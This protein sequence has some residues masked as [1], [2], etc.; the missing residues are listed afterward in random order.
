MGRSRHFR[1]GLSLP[2]HRWR[3]SVVPLGPTAAGHAN[4]LS[5]R[6]VPDLAS[7]SCST[8]QDP[9]GGLLPA[10]TAPPRV[11]TTPPRGRPFP[12]R[13]H[14]PPRVPYV[15]VEKEVLGTHGHVGGWQAREI[16]GPCRRRVGR[17]GVGPR[18]LSQVGAP[19]EEV[20]EFVGA[21]AYSGERPEKPTFRRNPCPCAPSRAIPSPRRPPA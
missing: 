9:P 16:R 7:S 18:V 2:A 5:Y 19:A 6:P 14:Q 3:R 17:N 1:V 13:P 21:A 11:L 10:C 15:F 20:G 12:A 4:V 8:P